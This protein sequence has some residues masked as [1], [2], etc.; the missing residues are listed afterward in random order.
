MV[1]R[2]F[3]IPTIHSGVKDP[4]K[5]NDAVFGIFLIIFAIAEIAYTR[6]FPSLHGQRFGASDF[7]VLLGVGLIICGCILL[8]N[9]IKQRAVTRDV[10][11]NVTDEIKNNEPN[12][13]TV[14][15]WAEKPHSV[16]NFFVVLLSILFFIFF[17]D[18]LGFV[19]VAFSILLVLFLRFNNGVV[20]SLVAALVVTVVTKL[21]FG[22]WLLVPLPIGPL[23]F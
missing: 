15:G 19:I 13:L 11:A 7:P 20:T 3:L 17:V 8:F 1:T 18:T 12:L 22:V 14:R 2:V 23:G 10:A 21:L 4:M 5:F 16:I 9:G 6:T